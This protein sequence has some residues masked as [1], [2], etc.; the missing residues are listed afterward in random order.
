MGRIT[1]RVLP[2]V[3]LIAAGLLSGCGDPD[4][5]AAKYVKHGE[6]LVAEGQPD[7]ARLEFRNALKIKPNLAEPYYQLGLLDEAKG[8]L[9]NAFDNYTR[10]EQQNATHRGALVK[11][12]G[13]YFGAERFDDAQKRLDTVLK[14][15]PDDPGALALN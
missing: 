10:A 11:L 2:I 15:Y 6:E 4:T 1:L 5:R 9:Q 3:G 14:T 8:D 12:A 7:K 13:F